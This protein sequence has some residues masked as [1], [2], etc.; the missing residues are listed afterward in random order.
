MTFIGMHTV[1]RKSC[2][3]SHDV[4]L[5]GQNNSESIQ[6]TSLRNKTGHV[7]S[8]AESQTLTEHLQPAPQEKVNNIFIHVKPSVSLSYLIIYSCILFINGD[9]P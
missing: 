6:E 1:E 9:P 3:Y 4:T 7:I 2:Q 5:C 8:R